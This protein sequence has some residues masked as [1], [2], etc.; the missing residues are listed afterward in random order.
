MSEIT[1][2]SIRFGKDGSRSSES[3]IVHCKS[4]QHGHQLPITDCDCE[5]CD[6]TNDKAFM[7]G[8]DEFIWKPTRE[9]ANDD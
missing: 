6:R 8:I 9:Q 1:V 2:G 7:L 5:I 4:R 3:H